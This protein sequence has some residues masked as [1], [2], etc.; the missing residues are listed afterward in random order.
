MPMQQPFFF[1]PEQLEK[2]ARQ[3]QDRFGKQEP[4]PHVV[5]DDLLP[6]DLLDEVIDEC[7]EVR[8]RTNWV[9]WTDENSVKRGLRDDWTMGPATRQLLNQFNSASF[10]NF[11]EQLTGITGLIPDPHYF[12]G[13]LHTIERGG[14]LRVH[15]DFNRYPRLNLDRRI[16]ALLYLNHDWRDEWGGHLELWNASL[17]ECIK[18][19]QPEFNRLVIFT[20]TDTAFH[21]HPN[22]LEC[23]PGTKRRS[24]ALYY[25][26]NGRPA[27][28]RARPHGTLWQERPQQKRTVVRGV[29]ARALRGLASVAEGPARLMRRAATILG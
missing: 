2:V 19:I 27:V 21:G 7:P 13:G 20:T 17:T 23:P 10:I 6:S 15:A 5:I 4:F 26:S 16:N 12:G 24:L 3:E 22:P 11:L 25:Y 29:C 28:E 14:Y 18:A 8:Q 9:S 1:D